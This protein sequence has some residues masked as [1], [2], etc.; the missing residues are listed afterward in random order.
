MFV[1]QDFSS[2]WLRTT[3]ICY[4]SFFCR[5]LSFLKRLKVNCQN[6]CLFYEIYFFN[7]HS[8]IH[9]DVYFFGTGRVN[10]GCGSRGSVQTQTHNQ[11]LFFDL[12]N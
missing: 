10:L 7:L 3:V 8:L 1:L 4:L 6:V 9:T 11:N 12:Q 5:F 2:L